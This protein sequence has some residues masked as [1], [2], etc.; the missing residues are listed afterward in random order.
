MAEGELGLLDE[1]KVLAAAAAEEGEEE[2][3]DCWVKRYW[4]SSRPQKGTAM[5]DSRKR[6][7][8]TP[9]ALETLTR[10]NPEVVVAVGSSDR[11]Q[12]E[13]AQLLL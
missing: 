11:S 5:L 2:G 3:S 7:L 6:K 10:K 9:H 8:G 1:K 4:I 13:T 12:V